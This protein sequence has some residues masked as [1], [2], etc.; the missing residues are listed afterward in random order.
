I[1]DNGIDEN[2]DGF[3][4]KTWYQDSDNDNFGNSSQSLQANAKPDNYVSVGGDCDDTNANIY[5]GA[6]EVCDGF[7]NDCD[8]STDENLEL[9]SYYPDADQDGYGDTNASATMVCSA[10]QPENT[11][12]NNDDCDDSNDAINPMASEIVDNGIDE[13][14][15]GDDLKTWYRDADNDTY[16]NASETQLAN[17][18][19][20]GYVS[21][22]LDCD[23]TNSNINPDTT[24][25]PDNDIDEDCDGGDLK[26]WYAD[27][28]NDT[29]GD[30]AI[31]T[32]SNDQP[33]GYVSNSLDC[34]DSNAAINPDATEICDGIDNNCDGSTDEGLT[35]VSYYID[36]DQD[37]YGDTNASATMVCSALQPENTVTNNL[38]CDDTNNNINPNA[39]EVPDNGI[40]EDCDGADLKTWYADADNDTFGNANVSTQSNNQPE[41]YVSNSLDCDDANAA[42]NP[43]ASEVCDGLDNDCD[44]S[45]DEGLQVLSYYPDA[46]QDGYGDIN[47][48]PTMV[49]SAL[50]PANTVTNNLDCNDNN[51]AIN[52]GV[53]EI[54][55]GIDNDCDG[56]IDEG[57]QLIA[58]YPDTDQ[59]SYGDASATPTIVCSALQPA[60]TVTNNLD[61]ND[62]DANINPDVTE[63]CDGI[64]NNCDGEVDEGLQLIDYYIDA[65][66]DGYGDANATPII[67]CSALK[68]DNYVTDN[69][70]CD[71]SDFDVNPSKTEIIGNLKDDDCNPNTPDSELNIDDDG[72]GYTENEGDCDDTKS[73][74]NPGETEIPDNGI[75]ENCDG[76]DLKTWYQDSDN[77]N[78]GNSSQSLQANA[79]P[80]NYVSV[81]GDCDDT[82]A[83]IYP[84]APEVCDGF[85]NDCDGSTD[86]N[87]ELI[88]YY[89]DA[90]Q[91]GYGDTNAS[92]TMV[93]SALQ[94]ENTVTNND[95]CDDSNDAINPMAS[96]IVDNGI[97]EDCDGDDLKTWYRDAD[98]DTYGNASET[99]LANNQPIGY[100]SNSLDCDDT[101]SNINPDTTEIPDNDI[102]E[103]CDGGD[104]KTWYADADNDTYGDVAISTQSND[105][106]EGYVSNSLDCDDSNAAINPD[107]TEICDGIDNNCDG[108]TDE[109]L[110]LV[111]YYIDADQDGYGDTN[112]SA[113]MVCSALQPENTV[114]NNLDC[115]DTNNNINPN[116]TEVPDNGID[117][118]C[119]GADLKTWYADADNDT[120]GNANVSTQSNN[121]PEGYVSNSLDCDD[122]NAAI[123]PDASEVCDGLDND[124]DGSTDE[125]LQVLSYY[126]DADQDGYGDINSSPTMVC[127][128]L[129]PANTVTNNLDCNDNNSAIN[130]GVPEICDG[131]DNDCDGSIDEG[132][133]LIAYYPD[134]DQDS[135]G[136]ASATPTIVCSAL[137]PANTVTN[138]LDC[139]DNDANINP[140]VNEIIGNL[141]DDD[142]NPNTPDSA[143]N[144]DD[145][146]DG[147]SENEGDCDD[148]KPSINPGANEI[149]DNGID[150]D[151]DGY[152]LKTWYEDKDH[153][154]FGIESVKRLS[155]IQPEGFVLIKNDC[156]DN[157]A[158][159]YPGAIE[160]CDG[161]D[162]D[163]DG[164]IDEGLQKISYY[165]DK[166]GDGYGD[167]YATPILVCVALQ[168]QNTVTNNLDLDDNNGDI[169]P[170]A[171][172]ICD[173][174]DNNSNGVIDEGFDDDL[175]GVANCF[176]TCPGFDDSIDS[177]SDGIPDG[178]DDIL[179]SEIFSFE[180][181]VIKP[182]PFNTKITIEIPNL[183]QEKK[184][185]ITL[186]DM[187]GSV[188]INKIAKTKNDKIH[189]SNLEQ[190]NQGIYLLKLS[191]VDHKDVSIKRLIKF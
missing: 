17:N 128:A 23:D 133:Q 56:S 126:P 60:N 145:D 62:N 89:P 191:T 80:D 110:T 184:L 142:C 182:N 114:T 32:Q 50:Q 144:I 148:T 127:S 167:Y 8:G 119:D 152:D 162:N 146:G 181:V 24:E 104:L 81:G 69:S 154:G 99:Q 134:T 90:D 84:G 136:D 70:D 47:S 13:D 49:C 179:N 34:D 107:A 103:D 173:G 95:D 36:A 151:C 82:N 150:E 83:N 166:D 73:N 98:N 21:N 120:F 170:D 33:E 41:G 124:C 94:P 125:G 115:D 1:P 93:C 74:I 75:D 71:D 177:D 149:V 96:E 137:Q 78:F 91:D 102:D 165:P 88:S 163:C 10:L 140:D 129:Q 52:P 175:D 19:P 86:E 77:D 172:E 138:N 157:N 61:C 116:A 3:D 105:Q 59:D 132:L 65:D 46:D 42:I 67:V 7:D 57:L 185:H 22:S 53:P 158:N 113:T 9:I 30:V 159:I 79:K 135:Y 28:D 186:Y 131:I 130:P 58:Y 178:C 72:D 87:L 39:T 44:G 121:Q 68:P 106:P 35:L 190:L 55:D 171:E 100:V 122:A 123:N 37:G 153:D 188:I 92:A 111:S 164:Q 118:D 109:G 168:P 183:I 117:E 101:N 143:L 169:N 16:G 2:C 112:A 20:I 66:S 40:D 31:S 51:S 26:T 29:Y 15:D 76:F 64:D 174:I 141:K 43:D 108:S 187:K 48:S 139:N 155:N 156:N 97:D 18:Q 25:I 63:I 45:T 161:L 85:D 12:T 189:I 180:N 6:P 5:P 54:C 176:D 38:D 11:V 14:C 147:Y 160:I 4:L 27:A